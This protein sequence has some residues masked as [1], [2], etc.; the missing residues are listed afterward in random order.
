MHA[1]L[2]LTLPMHWNIFQLN[3]SRMT[4]HR[5]NR[6]WTE[7]NSLITNTQQAEKDQEWCLLFW[8]CDLLNPHD[9]WWPHCWVAGYLY[10]CRQHYGKLILST[11]DYFAVTHPTLA[12]YLHG[13]GMHF[14]LH[15]LLACIAH[16]V[17]ALYTVIILGPG[18]AMASCRSF[19]R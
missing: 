8:L 3:W 9:D 12:K 13:I 5:L 2:T 7:L 6:I 18:L 16:H 4:L 17:V 15:I 10:D 19:L 14:P 11:S 1:K